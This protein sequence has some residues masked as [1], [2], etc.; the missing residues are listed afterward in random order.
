MMNGALWQK[1]ETIPI[2]I[3]ALDVDGRATT[4]SLFADGKLI[5]KSDRAPFTF[6]WRHAP[7]GAHRLQAVASD[8]DRQTAVA[9]ITINVVEN[10]PPAVQLTQPREG[11]VFRVRESIP[12][13]ASA[14]DR[15]GKVDR[16]EFYIKDADLFDTKDRL[17]GTA[18]SP[19]YAIRIKDLAPGHYM[20]IAIAWDN[21]G[22]ASAAS[23]VHFEVMGPHK[24]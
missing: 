14:S 18:K 16:V 3:Q 2:N 9:Y 15:L 17:A 23:P 20:L 10:L 7:L 6:Q 24:D 13:V 21:R 19:P 5:G 1:G 22:M 8:G 12:A 11:S 4:I